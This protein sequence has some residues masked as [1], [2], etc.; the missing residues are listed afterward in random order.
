MLSLTIPMNRSEHCQSIY[1]S[2]S[3]ELLDY[4]TENW[5]NNFVT[6]DLFSRKLFEPFTRRPFF[7]ILQCN[8][9][10]LERFRRSQRCFFSLIKISTE[11]N[12]Q[13]S[14]SCNFSL[15]EFLEEDDRTVFGAY[16]TDPHSKEMECL[17]RVE[18]L[19]S[20]NVTNSFRTLQQLH[21]Y[22]DRLDLLDSEHLRPSWDSYF[23][24][25][26]KS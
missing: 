22:L 6:C 23:M 8:A 1:F 17:H 13:Y 2:T 15:T 11:D 25:S 16:N 20:I 12:S 14:S 5:R 7:L 19:I 3:K 10:V 21:A 9:P 26:R 4:V 18:D 24:V